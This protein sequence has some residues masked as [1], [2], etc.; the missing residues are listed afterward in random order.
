[1]A[2]TNMRAVTEQALDAVKNVNILIAT[3]G[4][5]VGIAVSNAVL[6]S[7]KLDGLA[8]SAQAVLNTNGANLTVATRNIDD[9]TVTVKQLADDLQAGKGLAGAV[10]QNPSLAT[11]FQ[12]IA[13]NL[14]ITSSNLNRLGLWGI[15]WS[16]KPP[17]TNATTVVHPNH[18][19]P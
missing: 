5:Q 16:H 1:V 15:L 19:R 9:I 13:S 7:A 18:P 12:A 11:N 14:A 2:V 10:L 6:F 17:G 8:D 4:A 3:N